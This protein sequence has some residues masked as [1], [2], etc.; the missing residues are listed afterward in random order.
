[1]SPVPSSRVA[2]ALIALLGCLL[3]FTIS[4]AAQDTSAKSTVHNLREVGEALTTCMHPSVVADSY[5]AIRITA[6]LGFNTRGKPLSSPQF[7]Y[8]TPNV[9]DQVKSEYKSAVLDLFTRCTPLSFSPEL[10]ATIAGVPLILIFDERGLTRVR[11]GGSSAYVAPAPLPSSQIPS[12]MSVPPLLPPPT[13]QEPP[14]WLPVSPFPF[15]ACLTGQRHHRTDGPVVCSS[16][17]YMPCPLQIFPSIWAFVRSDALVCLASLNI[18]QARRNTMNNDDRLKNVERDGSDQ[19]PALSRPFRNLRSPLLNGECS[20]ACA[21]ICS[22]R[23][24]G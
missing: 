15:R 12:A 17:D 7:T 18:N 2:W 14:I 1:M 23:L 3:L 10:G 6:R 16:P 19:V 8:V 4:G 24:E 5:Q 13:R 20:G 11:L 9:S 21:W 22:P